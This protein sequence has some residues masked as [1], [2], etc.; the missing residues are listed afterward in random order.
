[1]ARR[2]RNNRRAQRR[3]QRPVQRNNMR[4]ISRAVCYQPLRARI[5]NDPPV[6][7]R[8]VSGATILPILISVKAVG[9]P[10]THFEAGTVDKYSYLQLGRS[11]NKV[12][13][14]GH[15]SG[16][17]ILAALFNWMVWDSSDASLLVWE[18]SW[19][20]KKVSLWGPN[21]YLGAP[22]YRDA[23]VGLRVDLGEFSSPLELHDCG[24]TTRRPCM[25]I[26]MPYT[27]WF[28]SSDEP[29]IVVSP[30][31]GQ[32]ACELAAGAIWGKLHLSIQW[33]RSP[34]AFAVSKRGPLNDENNGAN[35]KTSTSSSTPKTKGGRLDQRR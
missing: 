24:T 15:L 18:T 23:E 3:R 9:D 22:H 28:N 7:S 14:D 25:A 34:S 32:Q 11:D 26:S 29:L 5:I 35:A 1:M 20:I 16:A 31:A 8:T 4:T 2:G 13:Q 30:D 6:I 12:L 27:F 17:D 33:R 19:A 10:S 21:P